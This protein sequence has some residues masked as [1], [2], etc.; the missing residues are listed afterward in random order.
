MTTI[1]DKRAELI[2]ALERIQ[3]EIE[4]DYR[5]FEESEE[6]SIQVTLASS[7]DGTE[8]ALQT[9]GQSDLVRRPQPIAGD[10]SYTGEVYAFPHWAVDSVYRDSDCAELADELLA[11][12]GDLLAEIVQ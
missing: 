2:A 3:T 9:E 10:N 7:D 12:L 6:P 5:A 1:F 11:Q 8:Y 4:D